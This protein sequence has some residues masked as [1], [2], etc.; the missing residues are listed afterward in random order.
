VNV[1]YASGPRFTP[2]LQTKAIQFRDHRHYYRSCV[3]TD[4]Y[5]YALFSGKLDVPESGSGEGQYVHVFDLHGRLVKVLDLG[6][7]LVT[8]ALDRSGGRMYGSSMDDGVI[9]R[10]KL[11]R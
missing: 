4:A 11:P 5:L 9:Y 7:D 6:V 3:F 8:I 1:P 10:F 2:N